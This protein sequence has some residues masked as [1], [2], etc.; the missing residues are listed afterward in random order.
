MEQI[1]KEAVESKLC[2]KS[3]SVWVKDLSK[4]SFCFP[5]LFFRNLLLSAGKMRFFKAKQKND[6]NTIFWVKNLS[7]YVA[8]HTWTD[9]WLNLGQIFDSTYF[10]FLALFLLAQ[11]MLKPLNSIFVA[12]PQKGNTTCKHNCAN[13]LLFVLFFCMFVYWGFCCVRFWSFFERNE[14][15]KTKTGHKTTKKRNKTTRCK[16]ENHLLLLTKQRKETTQTHNNATSLFRLQTNNTRNKK[17][18]T[19]T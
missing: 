2:P 11:N 17:A 5:Y 15:Q 16:Q 6:K 14:K 12:H 10:T 8:Q 9:F 3:A 4:S 7:N 18:R 13:W 1:Y 19:Q